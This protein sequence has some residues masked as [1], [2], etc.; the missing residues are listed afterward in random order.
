MLQTTQL[1]TVTEQMLQFDRQLSQVC[2]VG[3]T[4]DPSGQVYV[5][6]PL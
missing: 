4:N 3:F 5:Q 2:S 6:F 1:F